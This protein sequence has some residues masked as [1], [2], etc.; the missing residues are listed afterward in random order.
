MNE[1]TVRMNDSSNI[2]YIDVLRT[3]VSMVRNFLIGEL[4]RNTWNRVE[5][6]VME[7]ARRCMNNQFV[8]AAVVLDD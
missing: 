1:K 8:A 3:P 6:E 4:N 5:Y 2:G 7:S